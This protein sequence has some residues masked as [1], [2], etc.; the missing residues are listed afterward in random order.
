[1]DAVFTIVQNGETIDKLAETLAR[2]NPAAYGSKEEARSIILENNPTAKNGIWPGIGLNITPRAYGYQMPDAWNADEPTVHHEFRKMNRDTQQLLSQDPDAAR[3]ML[4]GMEGAKKNN[5]AVG[6]DDIINTASYGV[7]GIDAYYGTQI[8]YF[9]T[10]KELASQLAKEAVGKFGEE[11]VFSKNKVHLQKLEFFL[12]Q[13][14]TFHRLQ[15]NIKQIPRTLTKNLGKTA[16]TPNIGNSNARWFRR[17]ILIPSMKRGSRYFSSMN[18]LVGKNL[19]RVGRIGTT[20]TWFIPAVIGVYNTV[21]ASPA[22]RWKVGLENSFGVVLGAYG[23][24][25]GISAG[26]GIASI[27]AISGGW[28]FVIV[29]LFAGALGFIGGKLGNYLGDAVYGTGNYIIPKIN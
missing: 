26:V 3:A 21:T 20:T 23:T 17:E 10:V 6:W 1:M 29:A 19:V 2:K 27:L 11:R 4:E 8:K 9:G 22:D 24:G 18:N 7:T 28:A 13:N 15:E 16:P 5:W 12:S 25:A 14:P